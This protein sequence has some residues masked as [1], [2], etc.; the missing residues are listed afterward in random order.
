MQWRASA[1]CLDSDPEL[2]FSDAEGG[3]ALRRL[4]PVAET[5]CRRCPALERCAEYAD[6]HRVTGLW[7]GTYRT[8]RT[9][10]YT[11]TPLFPGAPMFE[12]GPKLA[13]AGVGAWVA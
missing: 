5:T 3:D 6:D 4:R 8:S 1:A 10:R 7:A 9:G 2:F 12:L 13:E 11:R